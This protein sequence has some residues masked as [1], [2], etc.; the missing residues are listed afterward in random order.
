MHTHVMD[1]LQRNPQLMRRGRFLSMRFAVAVDDLQ[2]LVT[3]QSGHVAVTR[4]TDQDPL[5]SFVIAAPSA[6][7]DE[8]AGADPK[9]GFND[10]LA[11]VESGNGRITG[12]DLLP[13]FANLLFVKGIVAAMFKGEASW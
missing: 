5:P 4:G 8:Y 11:L 1:A 13:F 7:W 10:V 12:D 9:P 3:V 2:H 6:A